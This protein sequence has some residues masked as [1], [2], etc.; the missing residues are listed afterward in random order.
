MIRCILI[1][2]EPLAQDHLKSLLVQLGGWHIAACFDNAEEGFSFA[3]GNAIELIFL[4]V[5]L[6]HQNGLNVLKKFQLEIPIIVI[7]AN[8]QYALQGF[9]LNVCDYLLK[10]FTTHR[11]Q[12]ALQ[13]FNDSAALRGSNGTSFTIRC[14]NRIER[15]ALKDLLYI[16]GM[17]DYRRVITTTKKW[18]T[19]QT[20]KEMEIMFADQPVYRIHKS[21][22]V[23]GAAVSTLTASRIILKNGIQLPVSE[24][25][26]KNIRAK[27]EQS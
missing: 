3:T 5:Q 2:D 26:K 6:G 8:S 4:D 18:M 9:D 21:Y 19:L 12:R 11:L 14:E 15:I 13:K 20:F 7:S 23:H 27:L 1:E 10:P 25:Y 16:E 24:S 17:G 22:M